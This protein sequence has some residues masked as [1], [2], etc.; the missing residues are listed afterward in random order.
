MAATIA[1]GLTE[2]TRHGPP[3]LLRW[4]R[5]AAGEIRSALFP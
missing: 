4:K 1:L 2:V 5:D 3:G